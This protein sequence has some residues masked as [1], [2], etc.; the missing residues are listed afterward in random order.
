RQKKHIFKN[1]EQKK[2]SERLLEDYGWTMRIQ[3]DWV[4]IREQPDKNTV[5]LGRSFPYRWISVYWVDHPPVKRLDSQVVIQAV[6]DY[7]HAVYD[8]INFTPYYERVEKTVLGKW[9]AWR[10]E[11]MWE[12]SKEPKGGP[13]VSF[14]F[15][16]DRTDRL[17]HINLLI[18]YPGGNKMLLLRQMEVMAR[19]FTVR[20]R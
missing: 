12:H 18:H 3:H 15:Y 8:N 6:R 7:P 5:W 10:V 9:D 11:G 14:L 4:M 20:P 16:D 19:T 13:F 1:M 2:L 17:Y